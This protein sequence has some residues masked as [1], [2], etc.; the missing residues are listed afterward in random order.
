MAEKF[1]KAELDPRTMPDGEGSERDM[2]LG[3]LRWHRETLRLKCSGLEPAQLAARAVPPSTMSLLGLVRHLAEVEHGWFRRGLS[4]MDVP[5]LYCSKAE[6]NADFDGAIPDP[7]CVAEGWRTWEDAAEFA[8]RLIAEA[9][10]LEAVSMP[11][12][13]KPGHRLTL[14]WVAFHMIEEY[15]QHNGHADL[16]RERIDG[17]IGL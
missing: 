10:S 13:Y 1:I 8:D 3:F 15:A 17:R 5:Y 14:R 9:P 16:L 4:G 12:R 6:P 11:N 2:L 7:D